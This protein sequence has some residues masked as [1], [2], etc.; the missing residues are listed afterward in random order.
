MAKKSAKSPDPVPALASEIIKS[1]AVKQKISVK[2]SQEQLEAI[3]SQWNDRDPKMPAEI[4][5]YAG[6]RAMMQLKVAGYRY[7]G[8]SCCV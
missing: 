6:R 1:Y 7:R 5:F 8:D 3:M 4:T 2:L